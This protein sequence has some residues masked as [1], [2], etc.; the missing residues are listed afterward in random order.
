MHKSKGVKR[1]QAK[2]CTNGQIAAFYFKD[3]T[4]VNFLSNADVT[5]AEK[6]NPGTILPRV[7]KIYRQHMGHVDKVDAFLSNHLFSNRNRK[8]TDTHLK[9]CLK[10]CVDDCWIIYRKLGHESIFL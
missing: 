9:T 7:V 3:R 10:M 8:W 6:T 1:G 4:K 5:S 2:W